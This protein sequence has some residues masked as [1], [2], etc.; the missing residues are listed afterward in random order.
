MSHVIFSRC[1]NC[2]WRVVVTPQIRDAFEI[3]FFIDTQTKIMHCIF[4]DGAISGSLETTDFNKQITATYVSDSSEGTLVVYSSA[5][6]S[7]G[8]FQ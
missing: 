6:M 7:L 1:K 4:N 2:I 5:V 8:L 3:I